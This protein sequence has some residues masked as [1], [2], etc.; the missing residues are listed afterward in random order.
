MKKILMLAALA[1]TLTLTACGGSQSDSPNVDKADHDDP[2][3]YQKAYCKD[4]GW[5]YEPATNSCKR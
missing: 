2:V 5:T 1:G 4:Q 3:A